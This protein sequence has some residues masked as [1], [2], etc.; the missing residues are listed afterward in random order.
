MPVGRVGLD[1]GSGA[2]GV[3]ANTRRDAAESAVTVIPT[4]SCRSS[5]RCGQTRGARDSRPNVVRKRLI[6]VLNV[7]VVLTVPAAAPGVTRLL[8]GMEDE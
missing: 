4:S 2:T 7:N 3:L 8:K 5:G 6:Q 1:A